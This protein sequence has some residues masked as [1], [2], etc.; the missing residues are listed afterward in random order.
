MYRIREIVLLLAIVAPVHALEEMLLGGYETW[1]L[2]RLLAAGTFTIAFGVLSGG[3]ARLIAS[4]LFGL[5]AVSELLHIFTSFAR[6]AYA[7]G[8]VTA[9]PFV[10]LGVTL[11]HAVAAEYR[12]SRIRWADVEPVYQ[13]W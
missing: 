4:S 11:L 1:A 2:G 8:V 10:V 9:V 7:P 13:T 5:A 6:S 3:T 12:R